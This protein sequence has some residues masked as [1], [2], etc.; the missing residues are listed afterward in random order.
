MA[1]V[2]I[3]KLK[4]IEF[5]NYGNEKIIDCIIYEIE[6]TQYV[7]VRPILRLIVD[8]MILLIV[9]NDV[10]IRVIKRNYKILLISSFCVSMLYFLIHKKENLNDNGS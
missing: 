8:L 2:L 10:I 9:L 3:N 5:D 1:E 7:I 4:N 6:N